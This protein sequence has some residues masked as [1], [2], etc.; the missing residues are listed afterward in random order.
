MDFCFHTVYSPYQSDLVI[1]FVCGKIITNIIAFLLS[2][3]M[4]TIL[5]QLKEG[6]KWK[7]L[8]L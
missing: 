7:T 6:E 4:R 2:I 5:L 3:Y 1:S 8:K